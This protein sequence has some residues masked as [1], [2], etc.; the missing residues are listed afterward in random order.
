MTTLYQDTYFGRTIIAYVDDDGDIYLPEKDIFGSREL[1]GHVEAGSNPHFYRGSSSMN[2]THIG[3]VATDGTAYAGYM[4]LFGAVGEAG[5]RLCWAHDGIISNADD[6]R[7]LGEYSGSAAD[8]AAAAALLWA[9]VP[10]T[11][12]EKPK[13]DTDIE[14]P[15]NGGCYIT[16]LSI[17]GAIVAC[18]IIYNVFKYVWFDKEGNW[19]QHWEG[20]TFFLVLLVSNI[21]AVLF[22]L[23]KRVDADH[24]LVIAIC[25]NVLGAVIMFII[26]IA[27][28]MTHNGG[29]VDYFAVI[30]GVPLVSIVLAVPMGLVST[31]II[32]LAAKFRQ[33]R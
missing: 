1:I 16:L 29:A 7:T 5:E 27:W 20:I 4:P 3:W 26:M 28:L 2:R 11:E 23:L 14:K 31:L 25:A 13:S 18:F 32:Y 17:L 33:Q 22:S 12:S 19:T 30:V 21:I 9:N 8:A 15:N 6:S 24:S 10:E